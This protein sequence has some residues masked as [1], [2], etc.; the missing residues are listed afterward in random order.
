MSDTITL[1][2]IANVAD[3]VS[4]EDLKPETQKLFLN[5]VLKERL[6]NSL[7]KQ[8]IRDCLLKRIEEIKSKQRG[9]V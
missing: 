4:E 5:Q 8:F 6:N 1:K 9:E 3:L 7:K 2:D